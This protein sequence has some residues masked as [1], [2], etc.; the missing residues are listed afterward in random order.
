VLVPDARFKNRV[1]VL[2][3]DRDLFLERFLVF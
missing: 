1:R 3:L 2:Y